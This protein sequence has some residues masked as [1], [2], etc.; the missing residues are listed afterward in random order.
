MR[1]QA[2]VVLKAQL[3]DVKLYLLYFGNDPKTL[4]IDKNKVSK[5]SLPRSTSSANIHLGISK[6]AKM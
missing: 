1:K 5:L 4:V 2:S 6:A 3:V